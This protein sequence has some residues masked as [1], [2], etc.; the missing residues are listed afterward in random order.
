MKAIQIE[1]AKSPLRPIPVTKKDLEDPF[2]RIK[3][4]I[5]FVDFEKIRKILY[6]ELNFGGVKPGPK[7]F[8]PV[9]LLLL[10][11][12]ETFFKS[13]TRAFLRRVKQGEIQKLLGGFAGCKVPSPATMSRF[14]HTLAEKDLGSKILS[15]INSQLAKA[16]II[17]LNDGVVVDASVIRS[18]YAPKGKAVFEIAQDRKEDRPDEEVKKEEDFH[19]VTLV[20][21]MGADPDGR[22]LKKALMIIFGFKKHSA[23]SAN[24]FTLCVRTTAA[25]AADITEFEALMEELD[26]PPRVRVYADK[27]YAS[28]KNRDILAAYGLRSGIMYKARKDYKLSNW[29]V[30]FNKMVSS[31]R[32]AIEHT[33]GNTKR[34]FNGGTAR[35]RG[36][37][38]MDFQNQI[39]AIA[40]NLYK[41]PK[42]LCECGA[43]SFV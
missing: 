2:V 4:I 27:G 5:K 6:D 36:L 15:E 30:K 9:Y 24:G 28:Q 7:P 16:G 34:W 10:A 23:C 13:S 14:K 18:P 40:H 42:I 22:W 32:V 8:D 35:Y 26:L 20:R 29:E 31:V 33:F 3:I 12:F 37:A 11:I 38:M 41:L 25:N 43:V 19:A 17:N 1:G 39:E 21:K